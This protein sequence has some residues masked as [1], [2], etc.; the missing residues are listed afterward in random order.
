[1]CAGYSK[2]KLIYPWNSY[3]GANSNVFSRG[4]SKMFHTCNIDLIKYPT[5]NQVFFYRNGF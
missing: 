3:H 4:S 2:L 5:Y 1:M